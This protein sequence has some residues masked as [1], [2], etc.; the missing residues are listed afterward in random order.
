VRGGTVLKKFEV[1]RVTNTEFPP[2][3]PDSGLYKALCKR[4]GQ[5]FK[6]NNLNPKVRPACRYERTA[7]PLR[8][9]P[10]SGNR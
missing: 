4:V 8:L 10:P 9:M 7:D 6:D 1:G 2:Y 5:Y 3:K